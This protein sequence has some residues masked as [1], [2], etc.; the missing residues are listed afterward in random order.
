MKMQNTKKIS[1]KYENGKKFD[2][3]LLECAVILLKI[4]TRTANYIETIALL[5]K[6]KKM[7]LYF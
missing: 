5:M 6:T 2:T 7:K 3:I 4:N 1:N